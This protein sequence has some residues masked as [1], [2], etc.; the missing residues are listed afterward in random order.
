MLLMVRVSTRLMACRTS[1]LNC[2]RVSGVS[3]SSKSF[4]RLCLTTDQSVSIELRSEEYGTL[5]RGKNSY[6]Q[7]FNEASLV[8]A[9]APSYSQT[10][11]WWRSDRTLPLQRRRNCWYSFAVVPP[12]SMYTNLPSRASEMAPKIVTLKRLLS[13]W[14]T[15]G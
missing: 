7:I 6:L 9:G 1:C 4:F 12:P 15:L 10:T 13:R 8:C 2:A 5:R 3:W 14:C 11:F